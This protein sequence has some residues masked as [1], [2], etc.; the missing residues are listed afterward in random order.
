M[1]FEHLNITL[2]GATISPELYLWIHK[3][4]PEGW[5]IL[6]LGSGMGSIVL[7]DRWK[8]I[9][10]EHHP[11]WVK[12]TRHQTMKARYGPSQVIVAPLINDWYSPTVLKHGL[13]K[14]SYDLLLIDGPPSPATKPVRQL[15]KDHLDLFCLD[16]PI[17]VDDTHRTAERS[18]IEILSE[19]TG[20][21]YEIYSSE[22][23]T[24]GVIP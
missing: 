19:R 8:M 18:L 20:R 1:Y 16:V 4:L 6:E 24:F 5:T 13:R 15:M 22:K 2:N 9:S 21:D 11:S 10:V 12:F 17:V 3:T 23:K 14:K 7:C